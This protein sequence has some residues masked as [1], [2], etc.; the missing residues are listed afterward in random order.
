MESLLC[1]NFLISSA[2]AIFRTTY[3]IKRCRNKSVGRNFQSSPLVVRSKRSSYQDFQEYAKPSQLLPATEVR[4]CKDASVGKMV[5]SFVSDKSVSLFKVEIQ[6]SKIYGSGLCD[7]NSLILLCLID[8]DGRAILQRL[9]A[10][11]FG[12][13]DID[14]VL[15]FQRG[16]VDEFAFVGPNIGKIAAV[17]IS[18]NSGQW[19]IGGISLT[20]SSHSQPSYLENTPENKPL[21]SLQYDFECEDILLGEKSDAPMMEFR[22]R[23]ITSFSDNEST[24]FDSTNAPPSFDRP[25]AAYEQSMKE[26]SYLKFSLLLY[27]TVLI[28]AGSTFAYFSVGENAS[29]VFLVG[30]LF[31]FFY[32]LLLQKSVDGI[33]AQ[34]F[35]PGEDSESSGQVFGSL[36]LKGPISSLALA[37]A[38]AVAALKYGLGEGAVRL[39]PKDVIFGMMG[40]L[41][42]KVSVVLAAYKPVSLSLRDKK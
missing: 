34:D 28:L 40:F 21:T 10:T 7:M 38:F 6:T 37:F 36:N 13:T 33:S 26:Y 1:S 23:S 29:F 27:D 4:D 15:H 20:V 8:E 31:G 11:S 5:S 12:A 32:L 39:T 9:P 19:R 22:P 41:M 17:W 18:L 14:D 35:V 25:T 3:S 24:L 30:G 16:A 2:H 42:C